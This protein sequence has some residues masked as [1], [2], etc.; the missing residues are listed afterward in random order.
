MGLTLGPQREGA[1]QRIPTRGREG[2]S[3]GQRRAKSTGP[4]Q[5]RPTPKIVGEGAPGSGQGLHLWGLAD[6]GSRAGLGLPDG[7]EPT[8]SIVNLVTPGLEAWK[9]PGLA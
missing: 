9:W 2:A 4:R 7:A 3:G 5:G 6:V 8:R 1:Q